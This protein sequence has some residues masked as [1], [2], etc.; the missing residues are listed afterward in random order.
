LRSELWTIAGWRGCFRVR[1]NELGGANL[2]GSLQS[3]FN[4]CQNV[5]SAN[6]PLKFGLLHQL[7]RL[8]AST[9]KK[10]EAAG[11][12]KLIGQILDCGKTCGI[13]R[14]HIAEAED[15][16]RWKHFDGVEYLREFVRC[17]E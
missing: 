3:V 5:L 16:D 17:S 2:G 7:S 10:E 13:N 15:D 8:F 9:A 4:V 1:V 11:I 6:V 14:G 12:V